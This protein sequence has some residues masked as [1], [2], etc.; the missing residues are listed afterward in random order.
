MAKAI[1]GLDLGT[2]SIK[3]VRGAR[4]GRTG[5]ITIDLFD[6]IPYGTLPCGYEAGPLERQREGLL[7]FRKKYEPAAGDELCLAVTGSEVFSRFINLPPVPESIGDIIRYE[8]RQQIPFDIDE[9]VWDYQTVKEEQELG[10]EIEVGLFAL[11]KERVQEVMELLGPWRKNLRVIQD[12]PLAVYNF[13]E[14][15]GYCNEPFIVVDVG[16]STSDLLILNPPRFWMRTLLVAGDQLTNILMQRFSIG[17][18]EAER[19]KRRAGQSEHRA[20][21]LRMFSAVLGDLSNE[22][23]RSLGYYKSLAR[24]VK[25]E[26]ILAIGSAMKLDGLQDMISRGLQYEIV[27][28][29]ALRHLRLAGTV[30]RARFLEGLPGACAALGLVVQGVGEGRMRVNLVPEEV[31]LAAEIDKKKPWVLAAAICVLLIAVVLAASESLYAG[32]VQ[33]TVAAVRAAVGVR[34]EGDRGI[35]GEVEE[36][37]RAYEGKLAELKSLEGSLQGLVRPAVDRYLLIHVLPVFA[38]TVPDTVYFKRMRL[39]WFEPEN[40]GSLDVAFGPSEYSYGGYGEGGYEEY[41]DYGY[42]EGYEE[43]YDEEFEEEYEIDEEYGEYFGADEAGIPGIGAAGGLFETTAPRRSEESQLVMMFEGE[44]L[45][46]DRDFIE[47]DVIAALEGAKYTGRNVRLFSQVA[48]LG[49]EE[50]E[51]P[52]GKHGR[53]IPMAVF[54]GYAVVNLESAP[55]SDVSAEE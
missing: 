33:G 28:L 50:V 49:V 2:W 30:D 45:V 41:G 1:W 53:R 16:A 20:R 17:A 14:Y 51:V 42:E 35:V 24:D 25:F 8:A 37:K 48:L 54:R 38:R 43:E 10:E 46:P 26:R 4:A 6:E 22:I 47:T 7:A 5:P 27:S 29:E 19:M 31:A 13:L 52:A 39:A 11:K 21:I 36:S 12:A 9:V 55:A 18:A 40:I 44:S 34:R 23:Q 32:A 3:V 15:E